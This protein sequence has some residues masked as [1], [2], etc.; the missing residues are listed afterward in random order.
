MKRDSTRNKCASQEP[1][2]VGEGGMPNEKVEKL[3]SEQNLSNRWCRVS[4]YV[5]PFLFHSESCQTIVALNW[6][7][8]LSLGTDDDCFKASDHNLLTA[9]S[10]QALEKQVHTRLYRQP[11]VSD[12]KA[13]HLLRSPQV[14]DEA[15]GQNA[16]SSSMD[17]EIPSHWWH[18][19]WHSTQ[20]IYTSMWCVWVCCKR[21]TT[22]I[23]CLAMDGRGEQSNY[24]LEIE[25][26]GVLMCTYVLLKAAPSVDVRRSNGYVLTISDSS[27]TFALSFWCMGWKV[28]WLIVPSSTIFGAL[29]RTS[30]PPTFSSTFSHLSRAPTLNQRSEEGRS[31]LW[32]LQ[33][34]STTWIWRFIWELRKGPYMRKKDLL[35]L[36]IVSV[37]RTCPGT[38]LLVA[39]E[40]R[41]Y[42]WLGRS[43]CYR[44]VTTTRSSR[45]IQENRP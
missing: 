9:Y 33:T 1:K 3:C 36:C 44:R 22:F 34:G 21:V 4:I 24:P 31:D 30:K 5:S 10:P 29:G 20:K 15:R 13:K 28:G 45:M 2:F 23:C 16:V 27:L 32:L 43:V 18:K 39:K 8:I 42:G 6:E 40:R 17:Q 14:D 25:Q 37:G 11:F 26:L 35:C 19:A 12:P 38:I 41:I 7:G